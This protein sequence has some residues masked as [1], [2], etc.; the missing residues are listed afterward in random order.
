MK[1]YLIDAGY[2]YKEAYNDMT[3]KQFYL[4]GVEY[5]IGDSMTLGAIH[6]ARVETYS[7]FLK[8]LEPDTFAIT[9]EDILNNANKGGVCAAL[10]NS[11]TVENVENGYNV[12]MSF[13][14]Q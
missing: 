4:V 10:D 7:L 3:H 11:I 13:L 5:N 12:A 8:D 6:L 9:L 1:K 14:I 2:Q